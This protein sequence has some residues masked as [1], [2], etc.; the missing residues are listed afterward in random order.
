MLFAATDASDVIITFIATL[1][2]IIGAV[3]MI[4]RK[5]KKMDASVSD[6]KSDIQTNHG[7]KPYEYLEM[8]ADVQNGLVDNK[9]DII[10]T[11]HLVVKQAELM[12][13]HLAQDAEN[14][15]EI[16]DM[17]RKIIEENK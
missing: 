1:P 7:K 8:I 13:Q 3:V 17:F 16:K 6:I 14:F 9:L 4:G 10:E 12:D 5:M 15:E 2:A 11:K